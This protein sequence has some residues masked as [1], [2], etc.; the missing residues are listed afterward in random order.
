MKN[1][2]LTHLVKVVF[3][4]LLLE[5]ASAAVLHQ[6]IFQVWAGQTPTL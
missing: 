6:A 2:R 1:L 4:A 3:F 5:V